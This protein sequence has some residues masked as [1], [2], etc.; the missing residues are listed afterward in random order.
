MCGTSAQGNLPPSESSSGCACCSAQE[1]ATPGTVPRTGDAPVAS[2]FLVAGMTCGHCVSSVSTELGKLDGVDEV[3]VALV[4]GGASKVSVH[5]TRPIPDETA[6]A[7]IR[8]AG[9]EL[10]ATT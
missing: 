3:T 10:V 8:N 1:Q 4:P 9:Y 2:E 5:G 6:G 7:A